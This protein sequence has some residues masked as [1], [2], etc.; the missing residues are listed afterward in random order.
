[1]ATKLIEVVITAIFAVEAA[2]TVTVASRVN[3]ATGIV[4][5]LTRWVTKLAFIFDS[6]AVDGL[7]NT[8]WKPLPVDQLNQ[9]V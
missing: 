6:T 8:G 3:S 7:K 2:I 1:M 9:L 4:D 5:L